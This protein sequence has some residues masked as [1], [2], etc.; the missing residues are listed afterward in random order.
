[1]FL[2]DNYPGGTGFSEPLF[3][4]RQRLIEDAIALVR[5]CDCTHGCPACIGPVLAGDEQDARAPKVLA[6]RVL[7]LLG[8]GGERADEADVAHIEAARDAAAGLGF[9]G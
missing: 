2:Y 6:L 3:G 4:Q 1:V 8:E 7:A 5:A 9:D